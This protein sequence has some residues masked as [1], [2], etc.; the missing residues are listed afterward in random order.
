M[1]Q[2]GKPVLQETRGFDED[3]GETYLLRSKEDAPD[4]RYMPDPNLPPLLLDDA[5]SFLAV[6][7]YQILMRFYIQAYLIGIR[8]SMPELPEVTRTRLLS[9]GLSLRD[10]DF[11]MTIDAG[12]DIGFDGQPGFG[13]VVSYFDSVSEEKNAKSAFNWSILSFTTFG[14]S[15]QMVLF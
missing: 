3:T 2:S 6:Q 12:K 10:V 14:L 11:L 4:Y 5:S 7:L 15:N 9:R 1:I 13:S 8:K